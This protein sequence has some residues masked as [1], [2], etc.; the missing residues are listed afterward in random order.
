MHAHPNHSHYREAID[1]ARTVL[2]QPERY[3]IL[4]T[5]T[6]GVTSY[7]EVI[8]IGVVDPWGKVLLDHLIKPIQKK[9]IPRPVTA[10]HGITMQMLQDKPVFG[11]IA[12]LL[13]EAVQQK[14][15]I[16][17]NAEF[18]RRLLTQTAGFAGAAI[19]PVPWECAMLKYAEYIGQWDDYRNDYR[20][21]KLRGGD[22]TAI[23]DCRATLAHITEM[24]DSQP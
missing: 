21:H 16:T 22:H 20:W 9:Y 10:I 23:G 13:Q 12:H 6:T 4:D 3:V 7:D 17:Y 18:D 8:Q 19:P 5:E 24:A 11:Q 14:T 2:N 1:W 15:I